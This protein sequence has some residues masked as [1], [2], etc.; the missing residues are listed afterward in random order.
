MAV[1]HGERGK[2][3]TGGKINIARKKRKYE[4]GSM[5]LHTKLEKDKKK[6]FRV[7][8]GKVKV[9]SLSAEFANVFDPKTNTT[10]KV[11][12]LH[13]LENPANPHLVRR[14]VIT[15]GS[16]VKTEIGN[17]R[18]ISRPSQHGIVNALLIEEKKIG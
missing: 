12:I 3:L 9:K 16:V 1:W 8:G 15:K 11:K 7:K 13:V 6:F 4:L 14:G 10:K 2:K 5:P 17:A 18:I